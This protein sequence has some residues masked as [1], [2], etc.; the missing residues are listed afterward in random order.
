VNE[1][2]IRQMMETAD[3]NRLV[4][5]ASSL[6]QEN[7]FYLSEIVTDKLLEI[8]PESA[9]YN[10][11]KGFILLESH[12][13]WKKALTHLLKAENDTDKNYD[14]FSPN[15]LSASLD[16]FYHI[17]KCYHLDDQIDKAEIYY[18]KF[19]ENTGKKSVLKKYADLGL[20]QIATYRSSKTNA[21]KIKID[22]LGKQLN[23]ENNEFGPVVSID[24]K[25]LW[26]S[27]NRPW[28]NGETGFLRD[29]YHNR[30][31]ED[32]YRSEQVG[33]FF[34]EPILLPFNQDSYNESISFIS[35]N[36]DHF[37][38]SKGNTE[39]SDISDLASASDTSVKVKSL[40]IKGFNTEYWDKQITSDLTGEYFIFSSNR[41]GSIGDLDLYEIRKNLNGEWS[42]ARNLGSNINSAF[43]EESPFLSADGR[44]LY[45]SSNGAKSFGGHDIF[46]SELQPDGTWGE[47]KNLG[48]PMNS[49]ADDI[50]FSTTANG[51]TAYFSSRRN[52]GFGNLDIYRAELSDKYLTKGSII[53]VK[54][55]G[56]KNQTVP[57]TICLE[58]DQTGQKTKVITDNRPRDEKYITPLVHCTDGNLRLKMDNTSNVIHN[59]VISTTCDNRFEII[60][61]EII[62][63]VR[64]NRVVIPKKY[65]YTALVSDKKSGTPLENAQVRIKGTSTKN[66]WLT[67]TC[68]KFGQVSFVLPDTCYMGD[69][70]ALQLEIES[71][72][73]LRA[74]EKVS[75]TLTE[76]EKVNS[77]FKLM[78]KEMGRDIARDMGL[79]PIYYDYAKATL[80]PESIK[81]L[82]KVVKLLN[83]NPK[84]HLELRSHTD[85][86]ASEKSNVTLSNRRAH[87]AAQYLQRRISN[88][89]RVTSFGFG[90][91]QPMVPC[92]CENPANP[93]SSEQLQ[94]NRRTEFIIADPNAPIGMN[95]TVGKE[96][97]FV[98]GNEEVLQDQN[99]PV[100]NANENG[101]VRYCVQIAAFSREVSVKNDFFKGLKVDKY[102]KD[103][104]FKYVTGNF[105]NDIEGAKRLK[106]EL[107]KIGFKDCFVVGFQND[108][109]VYIEKN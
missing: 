75:I 32:V 76:N 39:D 40:D 47:A 108:E 83:D 51:K 62:L 93:C 38:L 105:P 45:F 34:Q 10:Y 106:A 59:E 72:G 99:E 16:V 78:F 102:K 85:C 103:N 60:E 1:G 58:V 68:N 13:D 3:E 91:S 80:R 54:I 89:K 22:E 71:N 35:L 29:I 6:L 43:D 9:N 15:E 4:M 63:D 56:F 79:K 74:T 84:L 94:Q 64:N 61:K 100:T 101:T 36:E 73:Y 95:Y 86:I 57:S 28:L 69:V 37:L 33:D 23:T 88:P 48:F 21:E 82:D 14:M 55:I 98:R 67:L 41:P 42:E 46:M 49:V 8:N 26:F 18:N 53:Q 107:L 104:S 66:E 70:L 17:A 30:L 25:V 50:G 81:E 109:R 11:R 92:D 96:P 44:H 24:G 7:Y 87:S 5:E 52:G 97:T 20:Q 27:S 65:E 77:E 31:P 2:M 90:E 19:L 12:R